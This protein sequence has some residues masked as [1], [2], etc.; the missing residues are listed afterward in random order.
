MKLVGNENL[1]DYVTDA[2]DDQGRVVVVGD[3]TNTKGLVTLT[4]NVLIEVFQHSV[5]ILNVFGRN[6]AILLDELG[7]ML[8]QEE[9]FNRFIGKSSNQAHT[10]KTSKK[11]G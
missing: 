4:S 7:A 9:E 11:K 3:T 6:G 10:M 1:T 8:I 2:Q 5:T